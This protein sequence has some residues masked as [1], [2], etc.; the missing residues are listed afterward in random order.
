MALF[1]GGITYSPDGSRILA[2]EALSADSVEEIAKALTAKN[3]LTADIEGILFQFADGK[4]IIDRTS[5]RL[6]RFLRRAKIKV[7]RVCD[8]AACTAPAIRNGELIPAAKALVMIKPRSADALAERLKENLR[9]QTRAIVTDPHGAAVEII[10]AAV[11][12]ARA[13]ERIVKKRGFDLKD[14]VAFGDSQNDIEML[15][16]V[17][18]GIAMENCHPKTCAAALFKTGHHETDAIAVS[19]RKLLLTKNCKP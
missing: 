11:N 6:E 8:K 1:N 17:G 7:T 4:T 16:D 18:I 15:R 3:D 12:K 9:S 14:V 10:P 5:S 2:Q 13:I 19:I